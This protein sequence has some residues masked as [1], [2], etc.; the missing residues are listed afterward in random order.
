VHIFDVGLVL[1]SVVLHGMNLIGI[2][3]ILI[4][5]LCQRKV[6]SLLSAG[7]K[8]L[9]PSKIKDGTNIDINNLHFLGVMLFVLTFLLNTRMYGLV[10]VIW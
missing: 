2:I 8:A 3:L 9:L 6:Q 5:F 4:Y 1:D 7:C 10:M